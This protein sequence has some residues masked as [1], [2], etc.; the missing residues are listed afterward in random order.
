MAIIEMFTSDPQ[1]VTPEGVSVGSPLQAVANLPGAVTIG[2]TVMD[3]RVRL[4]S[5]WVAV[6][7]WASDNESRNEFMKHARV[8]SFYMTCP[9]NEPQ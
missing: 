6:P 8:Q 3:L 1:F 7:T 2:D 4:S 9:G 5:G